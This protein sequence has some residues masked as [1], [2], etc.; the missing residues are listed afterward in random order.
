MSAY[1]NV[2][3]AVQVVD[4]VLVNHLSYLD[5]GELSIIKVRLD[6]YL[7]DMQ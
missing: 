5:G 3:L 1:I 4:V 2:G 7:Y 6:F